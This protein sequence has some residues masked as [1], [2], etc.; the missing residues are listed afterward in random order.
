VALAIAGVLFVSLAGLAAFLLAGGDDGGGGDIAGGSGDTTT[1]TNDDSTDDGST[2]S[3]TDIAD[4]SDTT[5][6]DTGTDEDNDSLFFPGIEDAPEDALSCIKVDDE[7]I[8][9]ELV[10]NSS[11]TANYYLTI[12]FYD[13]GGA[14]LSDTSGYI[15]ALRPN[16]RTIEDVYI[17]E[18]PGTSCEV[19]ETERIAVDQSDAALNDVSGCTVTGPDFVDDVAAEVSAT[20]SSS[21][22]SDYSVDVAIIGPDGIRRGTGFTYIEAVRPGE[23]APSEVFTTVDYGPDLT[24][25]VVAVLRDDS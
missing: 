14:R 5:P 16:E 13:D 2:D 24:C 9:V 18:E 8:E 22:N 4:T 3:T 12:A 7:T 17:F 1:E 19:I 23:T 10:N 25:E 6:D 11:Y 20:N 21:V 15:T